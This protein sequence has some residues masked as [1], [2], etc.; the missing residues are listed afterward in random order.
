MLSP[1]AIAERLRAAG[2]RPTRQRLTLGALLFGSGTDRHVTAEEL[3]SEVAAQGARVSLATVYNALN[4]F[5]AAGLLREVI[6]G[7]GR[8]YFD[9]NIGDHHH[10]YVEDDGTLLDIPADDVSINRLPAAPA[11]M[12]VERVDV[13]VRVRR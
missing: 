4:Q 8:L 2:L 13:V 9:T 6:V 7:P 11:G 10:F 1:A 12:N 3:H 5:T